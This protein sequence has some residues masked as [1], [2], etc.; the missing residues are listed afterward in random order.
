M[1][2][3]GGASWCHDRAPVRRA[4]QRLFLS[5]LKLIGTPV[6]HA[7]PDPRGDRPR[8][9]RRT[10]AAAPTHGSERHGSRPPRRGARVEDLPRF[11]VVAVRLAVIPQPPLQAALLHEIARANPRES[12]R[13]RANPRESARSGV[14]AC[15]HLP[16]AHRPAVAGGDPAD[17][18]GSRTVRPPCTSHRSRPGVET[19]SASSSDGPRRRR[20]FPT[21]HR[22]PGGGRESAAPGDPKGSPGAVTF[23]EP[24]ALSL[25]QDPV[26]MHRAPLGSASRGGPGR[27][28]M[29]GHPPHPKQCLPWRCLRRSSRAA[30][31]CWSAGRQVSRP[32][33][34]RSAG[35]RPRTST[36]L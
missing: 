9:P 20:P 35:T 32:P 25:A 6:D 30:G 2:P 11:A 4:A 31:S 1:L 26:G 7:R 8:D 17:Q 23:E 5:A 22:R 10:G 28:R 3:P 13:I 16:G 19:P 15:P 27:H 21:P 12:A 33:S 34:R 18:T 24:G 29:H 36:A 14:Q